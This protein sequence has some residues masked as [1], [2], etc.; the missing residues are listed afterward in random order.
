M[1]TFPGVTVTDAITVLPGVV[2]CI[3]YA[4]VS[5]HLQE[6]TVGINYK[7]VMGSVRN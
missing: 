7:A 1:D 2:P 6:Q 3:A 5:D 4:S